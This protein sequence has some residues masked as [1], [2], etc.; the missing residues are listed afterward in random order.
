MSHRGWTT[1]ALTALLLA[2]PAL[3]SASF[4]DVHPGQPYSKAILTLQ[5]EGV[6]QGYPDGTYRPN[7][8]ISRAEFIKILVAFQYNLSGKSLSSCGGTAFSDVKQTAWYG[9]YVCAAKADNLVEGYPDGTFRPNTRI[10]FVEAA[11]IASTFFNT[12]NTFCSGE[13]PIAGPDG[14]PEEGHPWY[15]WYV[16]SLA[17]RGAVP[18]SIERFE[19]YITRGEMAEIVDR[20]RTVRAWPSRTFEDLVSMN[21]LVDVTKLPEYAKQVEQALLQNHVFKDF[22]GAEL[23]VRV[24]EVSLPYVRGTFHNPWAKE[25]IGFLATQRDESGE[26][27]DWTVFY[28]SQQV[29]ISCLVAIWDYG[30]PESM[31]TK[32]CADPE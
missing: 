4:L 25:T 13:E 3:A 32:V 16:R 26:T 21:A 12:L 15:E 23:N 24:D 11:K 31:A 1:I 27:G 7:Q 14:C 10:N 30:F 20:V 8:T 29:P 2:S 18:F 19:H 6:L 5:E 17:H 9:P 28:E 22:P